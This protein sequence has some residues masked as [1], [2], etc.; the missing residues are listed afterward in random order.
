MACVY[1]YDDP[2]GRGTLANTRYERINLTD[3]ASLPLEG[4]RLT[5]NP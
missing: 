4:Q 1:E 2:E 5:G 3:D